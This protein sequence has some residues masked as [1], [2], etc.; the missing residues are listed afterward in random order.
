[1]ITF[2]VSDNISTLKIPSAWKF[3]EEYLQKITELV[4]AY[5]QQNYELGRSYDET[6]IAPKK[7]GGRIY[8]Q[9][10]TLLKSV[11]KN[12]ENNEGIIYIAPIRSQI[13]YYLQIGRKNMPPRHSF[14]VGKQV[15]DLLNKLHNT[16]PLEKKFDFTT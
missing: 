5:V 7:S 14:G 10:G 12:I 15:L 1:M 4:R 6:D 2:E 9:T 13:A 16:T 8:F 3:K 11:L